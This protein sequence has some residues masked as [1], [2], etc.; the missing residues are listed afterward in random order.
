MVDAVRRGEHTFV[1][2]GLRKFL[3]LRRIPGFFWQLPLDTYTGN[4]RTIP[5]SEQESKLGTII[6]AYTYG[7]APQPAEPSKAEGPKAGSFFS[8]S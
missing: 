5:D 3:A 2:C 8:G 7:G 6:G 1:V 4:Y